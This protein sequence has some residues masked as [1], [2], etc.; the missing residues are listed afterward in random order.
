MIYGFITEFVM[1][2]PV[3]GLHVFLRFEAKSVDG[4]DEARP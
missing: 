1:P 4:R 3:P 2:G